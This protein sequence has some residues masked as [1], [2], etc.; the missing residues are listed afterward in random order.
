M[1]KELKADKA[2]QEEGSNVNRDK[3]GAAINVAS[4]LDTFLPHIKAMGKMFSR[5]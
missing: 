4:L 2:R 1:N 5:K 3:E